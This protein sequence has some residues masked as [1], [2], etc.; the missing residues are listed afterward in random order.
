M[1]LDKTRISR[2]WSN[3]S[4]DL[5]F[6]MISWSCFVYCLKRQDRLIL[7]TGKTII[8]IYTSITNIS[9]VA[10]TSSFFLT[11]PSRIFHHTVSRVSS[12]I[13]LQFLTIFKNWAHC[14]H[15]LRFFIQQTGS[16]VKH[17]NIRIA[18]AP[19]AVSLLS[20]PH[21]S[22]PGA[23]APRSPRAFAASHTCALISRGSVGRLPTQHFA[24]RKPALPVQ[25]PDGLGAEATAAQP[26]RAPLHEVH[27]F[28]VLL[29]VSLVH[30]AVRI[31]RCC[32]VVLCWWSYSAVSR[33]K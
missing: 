24:P 4:L 2:I 30:C 10:L 32:F 9:S 31:S 22:S 15:F 33:K 28:V 23:V 19:T 16:S 29:L 21:E 12:L 20:P 14:R 26:P 6:K 1:S 5:V 8:F 17:A 27:V 7:S 11:Y 3:L 13:S 18:A 25:T